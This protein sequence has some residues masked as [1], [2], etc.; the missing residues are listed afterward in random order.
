MIGAPFFVRWRRKKT[1]AK[2]KVESYH[3]D[4]VPSPPQ[5]KSRAT[6]LKSMGGST[7]QS[8]TSSKGGPPLP[9]QPLVPPSTERVVS[10]TTLNL[11]KRALV[12]PLLPTRETT[13]PSV[14]PVPIP[15][16]TATD[17]RPPPALTPDLSSIPHPGRVPPTIVTSLTDNLLSTAQNAQVP[18]SDSNTVVLRSEIEDLREQVRLLQLRE[19]TRGR[20]SGFQ[21]YEPPP[22][23]SPRRSGYQSDGDNDNDD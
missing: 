21:S 16:T 8:P 19:A 3:F 6:P 2:P 23:Y 11:S 18:A 12:S 1:A 20:D 10:A 17:A 4:E 14:L 15:Q 13:Q 7:I 9:V 22:Q 5:S